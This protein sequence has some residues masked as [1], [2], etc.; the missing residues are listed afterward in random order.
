MR[1]FFQKK[2]A[3]QCYFLVM[4]VCFC[5][6]MTNY[7]VFSLPTK[8]KLPVLKNNTYLKADLNKNG[9]MKN[10][11]L[12][13]GGGCFWCMEAIFQQMQ[14]VISVSSG[15]SGGYVT[16]PTYE[17]VCNGRT[18]HAEV[19]QIIFN[20]DKVSIYDMLQVFFSLHDPTTINQQGADVGEQYRSII[21]YRNKKQKEIATSVIKKLD[22]ENIFDSKIVTQVSAFN[23]FYAAEDYHQNYYNRNKNK[24]YC[25]AVIL[26]KLEKFDQLFMKLKKKG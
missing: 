6:I 14:G 24:G 17:E 10:D 20:A 12:T 3:F 4:P 19:I 2:F 18:G 22:A 26:P 1:N 15:Y 16:N 8:G 5:L 23:H 25:R 11:T 7:S 13:V 9:L 21:F